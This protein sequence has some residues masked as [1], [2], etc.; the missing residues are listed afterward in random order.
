MSVKKKEK[1][2]YYAD[3]RSVSVRGV[4]WTLWIRKVKTKDGD[5]MFAVK[6]L[7]T[8]YNPEKH[9]FY[10]EPLKAVIWL[11]KDEFI[12]FIDELKKIVE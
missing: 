8:K 3:K 12:K 7:Q 10:Y 5:T 4:E 2:V 1:V 11:K 6:P 9:E